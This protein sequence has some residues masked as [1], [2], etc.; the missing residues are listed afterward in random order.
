MAATG[1]RNELEALDREIHSSHRGVIAR[2][3][4]LP[5]LLDALRTR[6]AR[7]GA[8]LWRAQG[9]AIPALTIKG[10]VPLAA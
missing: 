1:R 6:H 10:T 2:T 7:R 8:F 5:P 4:S 3:D 9:H